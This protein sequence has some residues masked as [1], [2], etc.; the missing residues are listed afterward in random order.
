MLYF[1]GKCYNYKE[2]TMLN[3]SIMRLD[4]NHVDEYCEDIKFQIE[5]GISTMPLFAMTLTPEGDPAIDKASLLC[6]TYK[7]YKTKLDS[8]GLPSGVLIQAS[9][10][11]GWKLNQESAFQKYTALSN[12]EELAICCPY[13]KGFRKY[14]RAAA[15]TIA[16][17]AP[18][19]MMFDDDFRLMGDRPH[20]LAPAPC[21]WQSSTASAVKALRARSL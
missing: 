5:N 2:F 14:I 13:D 11:H 17:E 12:G 20:L 8:M 10:G 4:P 1:E 15:S 18:D 21:T 9:I 16:R 6:E 7:K 19:H 3:Y